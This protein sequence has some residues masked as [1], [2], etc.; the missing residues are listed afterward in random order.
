MD[1]QA[2]SQPKDVGCDQASSDPVLYRPL[3]PADVG[4]DWMRSVGPIRS[5]IYTDHAVTVTW[6]SLPALTYQVEY[7]NNGIDWVGTG[8][9]ISNMVTSASWTDDGS[10]TGGLPGNRPTRFYRVRLMP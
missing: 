2:R 6:D 8:Q 3:G 4:P 9:T 7:S 1:G 10:V 5:V